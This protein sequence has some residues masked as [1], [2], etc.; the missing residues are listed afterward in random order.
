MAEASCKPIRILTVGV[1]WRAA[2][3]WLVGT[4]F[5]GVSEQTPRARICFV[6]EDVVCYRPARAIDCGVFV[7]VLFRSLPVQYRRASQL[8]QDRSSVCYRC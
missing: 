1:R 5:E 6:H 8:R 2:A 4:T 3:M 7:M